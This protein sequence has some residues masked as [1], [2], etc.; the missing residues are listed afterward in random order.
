[1]V[2]SRLGFTGQ[3]VSRSVLLCMNGL[4]ELSCHTVGAPFLGVRLFFPN[5]DERMLA[6]SHYIASSL[7][8]GCGLNV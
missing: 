7:M 1:M 3:S 8:D 5:L 4:R 6:K 2:V